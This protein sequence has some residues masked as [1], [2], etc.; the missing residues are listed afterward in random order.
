MGR[1]ALLRT[2]AVEA[3]L[4]LLEKA[5][6]GQSTATIEVAEGL[7]EEIDP[8]ATYPSEFVV[9]RLIGERE[10]DFGEVITGMELRRELAILIQRASAN[11]PF[12]GASAPGGA[13]DLHEA[14]ASI[15]VSVRTL[16][17]WRN[18]GLA[19]CHL[20]F[21]DGQVRLGVFNRALDRFRDRSPE[22]LVRAAGFTRMGEEE[23]HEILLKARRIMADGASLNQA[24]LQVAAHSTR[25]HETIRQLLRRRRGEHGPVKGIGG[26][27]S[28]RERSFVLR[29]T[30]RGLETG[31][32]AA[33]IGRSPSSTRRIAAEARAHR[34]LGLRP[35]WIDLPAFDQEDAE[36]VLLDAREVVSR[37]TSALLWKAPPRVLL[38]LLREP[39]TNPEALLLPAM[40][41]ERRLAARKIDQLPRT[42]PVGRLDEIETGLRRADVLRRRAGEAVLGAALARVEQQIGTVLHSLSERNLVRWIAF[43]VDVVDEQLDHFDPRTRGEIE[44]RLDRRI[45]L[46]ID[47][48][49]ALQDR[50]GTTISGSGPNGAV[51]ADAL[52]AKLEC[53][54]EPL[55]LAAWL[56]S[57]LERL[58]ETDQELMRAR[59][60]LDSMRP[61][62][63]AEL[64]AQ[65]GESIRSI[66]TTL[67][68]CSRALRG[69]AP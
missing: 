27:V 39:R 47:K 58:T 23:E 51:A 37:S 3:V 62:T 11:V 32:I 53:V 19:L 45:S 7:L 21:P 59:F 9:W 50:R 18:E 5:P 38:E 26:R 64:A 6:D 14:A 61:L 69:D 65:F 55:G 36:R 31:G 2:L 49:I 29:A 12:D 15:G 10:T 25:A 30:D 20:R 48:Q 4:E 56:R 22:R 57:R 8:D 63:M 34:L 28:D 16:Q 54:R 24:A 17:R 68:Q 13:M 35:D 41:F 44:P 33:R 40:H 67:R 66:A 42:P 1:T 52:L 60:G 43:C 46:E